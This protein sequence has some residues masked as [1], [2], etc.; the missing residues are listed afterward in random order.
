[1]NSEERSIWA[2]LLGSLVIN[3]YFFYRIWT[4]FT[5]GTS[6]APDGLQIWA[7]TIIWAIPVSI[8]A[9]ISLTILVNIASG[10]ITG[11]RASP[12]LK[13]ERDRLF[14]LWGL[15]VTMGF[16]VAFFVTAV[17]CLALG[18]S[19]FL[20]ITLVYLGCA[21]GDMAGNGLKLVLYRT[22]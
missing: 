17:L 8:V 21:F 2:A 18:W 15:G 11:D 5:D 6:A 3:A 16:T 19:G 4:M 1:M 7:R 10:I 13:D 12:V 20:A 14:Q 9:T 22:R